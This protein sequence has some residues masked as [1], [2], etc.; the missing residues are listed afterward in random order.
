M[1]ALERAKCWLVLVSV[2]IL[3]CSGQQ[4]ICENRNPEGHTLKETEGDGGFRVVVVGNHSTRGHYSPND[5]Y[6]GKKK[7]IIPV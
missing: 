4:L 7:T 3:S 2:T 1:W 5:V 6:T